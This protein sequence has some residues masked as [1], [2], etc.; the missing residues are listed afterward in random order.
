VEAAL[1]LGAEQGATTWVP[2]WALHRR[3]MAYLDEA[4]AARPAGGPQLLAHPGAPR[5]LEQGWPPAA[6]ARGTLRVAVGPEG[7][8]IQREVDTFVRRGFLPV[9]LGEPVLDVAP[10]VAVLLGQ[11]ALL[12]RLSG[13]MLGHVTLTADR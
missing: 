8:W 4:L 3:L 10:A 5:T 11:L 6:R 9:R 7:G 12:R 13:P 2:R 1:R